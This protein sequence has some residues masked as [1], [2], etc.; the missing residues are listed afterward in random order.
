MSMYQLKSFFVFA[1]IILC[2]HLNS[3]DVEKLELVNPNELTHET[4]FKTEAQVKQAVTAVYAN[5]QTD[6]LYQRTLYYS[7]DFMAIEQL[8]T[9]DPIFHIFLEYTFNCLYFK[10]TKSDQKMQFCSTSQ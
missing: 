8:S 5:L 4:F 2:L 7:M 9:T 10:G 6:G 3:C 1:S